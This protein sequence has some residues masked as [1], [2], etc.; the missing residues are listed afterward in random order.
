[1]I[2]ISILIIPVVG[3]T[4]FHIVLVARGR[5]TNEQVTNKFRNSIN[6]FSNGLTNNCAFT[7]CGPRFPR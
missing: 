3:L 4:A 7:L 2:L 5:T 1:M 6:P